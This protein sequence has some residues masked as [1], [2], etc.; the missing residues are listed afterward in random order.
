MIHCVI[1]LAIVGILAFF[2]GRML[3]RTWFHADTFP[4]RAFAFEKNGRFYDR[5]HISHWKDILPDMSRVFPSLIMPKKVTRRMSASEVKQ[6]IQETCVAEF[7]HMILI[8]IGFTCRTVCTGS[9][10]LILSILFALG[11][12]PFILIQRYNRPRLLRL[13]AILNRSSNVLEKH[14]QIAGD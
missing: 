5:F 14:E 6:L 12:V 3:P 7:V 2:I 1:Y 10:S 8:P 11:N 9:A 13:Y 4:F